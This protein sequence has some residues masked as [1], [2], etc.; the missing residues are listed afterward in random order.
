MSR[1]NWRRIALRV[2]VVL[3]VGLL[4]V[5]DALVTTIAIV[6]IGISQAF[7]LR[8]PP[9]EDLG[10]TLDELGM[11]DTLPDEEPVR[12]PRKRKEEWR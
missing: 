4:Y 8:L 6:L 5:G 12:K 9:E 11:K 1:N 2:L 3:G 7:L 10:G